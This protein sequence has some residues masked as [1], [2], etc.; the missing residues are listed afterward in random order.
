MSLIGAAHRGRRVRLIASRR[1]AAKPLSR[2]L[3]LAINAAASIF[4]ERRSAPASPDARGYRAR[5]ATD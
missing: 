5:E 1:G 4:D 3:Y 2:D